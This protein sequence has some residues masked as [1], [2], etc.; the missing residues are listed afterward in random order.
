HPDPLPPY[1]PLHDAF[2]ISYSSSRSKSSQTDQ[3]K[4]ATSFRTD[5]SVRSPTTIR[6][7]TSQDVPKHSTYHHRTTQAEPFRPHDTS[8]LSRSEEHTSELQS[9]DHIVCR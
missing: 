3:S 5:D 2:P 9:P 6:Y 7:V 1:H 4:R 8:L